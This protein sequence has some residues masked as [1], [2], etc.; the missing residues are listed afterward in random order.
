MVPRLSI[1]RLTGVIS[2][3]QGLN[4]HR[5]TTEMNTD[6][7]SIPLMVFEPTFPV[8]DQS[9]FVRT[10]YRAA[11]FVGWYL[12]IIITIIVMLL[13]HKNLNWIIIINH[14]RHYWDLR[15]TTPWVLWLSF[16]SG[17]WFRVAWETDRN[18]PPKRRYSFYLTTLCYIAED[19]KLNHHHSLVSVCM[20]LQLV[21]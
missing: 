4:L 9:M 14:R 7:T 13:R 20:R 10:L 1:R 19:R 6:I 18:V 16:L 12:I 2:H 11:S 5:K 21:H 3:S 15:F 17:M 8:F